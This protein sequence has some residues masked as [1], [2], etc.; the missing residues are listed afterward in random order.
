M[1][2]YQAIKLHENNLIVNNEFNFGEIK[3]RLFINIFYDSS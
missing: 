1:K 2:N 3:H